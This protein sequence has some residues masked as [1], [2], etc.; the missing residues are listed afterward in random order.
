MTGYTMRPRRRKPFRLAE[1]QLDLFDWQASAVANDLLPETWA[2]RALM[3]RLHMPLHLARV[4]AEVAG[5]GGR[6]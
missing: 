5:I 3:R 1:T 4:I 6:T 2:E